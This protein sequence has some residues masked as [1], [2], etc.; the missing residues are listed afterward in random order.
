LTKKQVKNISASVRQRLLN[1]SRTDARP[2]QELVQY[3][4]ME[5]FL[6]RLAQS[7]HANRFILKGALML[8][9][10]Q[11]PEIRSTM[12]IDLLGKTDND[13]SSLISNIT[14]ILSVGVDPDGLSFFPENIMGEH[15]TEDAEYKGVRIWFP[16]KLDTMRL[17]IQID[18]G[19]G[20]I[21]Y[22]EPEKSEIPTMLGL[23]APQ[24]WCYSRESSI[25]EKFEAMLKRR[26]LNS[27]MKDFYDIWLLSRY[28]EFDGKI[29]AEAIRLT[30]E[31]RGTELPGN[32]NIVAFSHEFIIAKQVQWN[33]FRKKLKR[34]HVPAEFENVVMQVK[35][36]IS[37]LTSALISRKTPP[38]KWTA[39]GP[40]T[41]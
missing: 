3:Y 18:I 36:F 14:D 32:I 10:W 26:E 2:F 21:I 20:D 25:A 7:R 31:Q 38:S 35:E 4:A 22:P 33:A 24:L 13:V 29:L 40:W 19:F 27:R 9:V 12:D 41:F 6:Y 17:N 11:A 30:L 28:F 39:P 8:R 15:I 1:K 37:P 23:P 5:R 34:D 16:A